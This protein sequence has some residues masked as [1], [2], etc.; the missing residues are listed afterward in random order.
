MSN[1]L[2]GGMCVSHFLDSKGV[3]FAA[4]VSRRFPEKTW[5]MC[6]F[7]KNSMVTNCRDLGGI[8]VQQDKGVQ[9]DE[10]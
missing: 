6:V 10:E 5:E 1:T 7:C 2:R 8:L 4:F 9:V 3:T